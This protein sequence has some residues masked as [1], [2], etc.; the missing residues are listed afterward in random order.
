VPRDLAPYLDPISTAIVT[1]EVQENF[2]GVGVSRPPESGEHTDEAQRAA[3]YGD[4]A[5]IQLKIANA[6]LTPR[7]ST[8]IVP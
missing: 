1:L 3:G 6:V 2:W 5:I 4:D 8:A 7:S